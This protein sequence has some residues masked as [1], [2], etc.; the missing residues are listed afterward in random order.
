MEKNA[1]PGLHVCKPGFAF[2]F[3]WVSFSTLVKRKTTHVYGVV[4]GFGRGVFAND[5]IV[6]LR[7]GAFHY[8]YVE[9]HRHRFP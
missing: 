1:K 3:R 4:R 2:P 9:T 6:L 7:W 5:G 8:L